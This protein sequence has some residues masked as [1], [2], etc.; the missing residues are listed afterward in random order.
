MTVTEWSDQNRRL[1]SEASAEPGQWITTR[2]AYQKGMM[3]AL[4][5]EGI[6]RIVLMTSSQ[7]GKTE[8]LNNIIGFYISQDP[9]PILVMQPTLEIA[10]TW[11]KDRLSP[12]LR[13]T[14]CLQNLVAD[15]RARDSG[16]TILHKKFLGGHVTAVGANSPAGLA[17]RPIRILL[18]DEVDRY[19]IS[20]GTEG[21]PLSLAIKR[22]ATFWNRRVVLA[23][24]PTIKGISR[25]ESEYLRSDQR[26]Y[27][28]K[29][30]HCEH[31]QV[32]VW[33]NVKWPEGKPDQAQYACEE[34]GVLWTEADRRSAVRWGEWKATKP[35]KNIAGFH[36]N[37]LYSPWSSI[38]D[39]A[40]AFL[41]AKKSAETLKA[42]VNTSLGESWEEDAERIDSATIASRLER[43][44]SNAVPNKILAITCGVDC[45]NDRLEIERVGWCVDEECYSL[46]H[47]VIF[48]DPSTPDL[49]KALDEYLLTPTI[50]RDG[51][52]L[53]V[54]A[55][56]IDSGGHY[57]QA[58]Y[59]FC[60]ERFRRRVYA[61]KGKG[62]QGIPIWPKR[63]SKNNSG[64][65]NLFF[66]GVD[67]AKDIIYARL[68]IA[69]VGPGYCHFPIGRD[70]AYFDQ[71][72]SEIIQTK[73]SKGFATRVYCLPSGKRNEALDI[74]VYA[75]A[76]LQSLN[77]RWGNLLARQGSQQEDEEVID[78]SIHQIEQQNLNVRVEEKEVQTP[79]QL[80]QPTLPVSRPK[81]TR[82]FIRSGFMNG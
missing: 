7:V 28:C 16:N 55:T 8:V 1:S 77:I 63:A 65:V 67:A 40:I 32:L 66:I 42:W 15:P 58:V 60:R 64:R 51:I 43:W 24:T 33:G 3:D 14:P 46:E 11:A 23:S 59:K 76:A 21:D 53:P 72:T 82:R 62:G 12:M 50:R 30:P 78:Q 2:A 38:A 81:F 31:K 29:C 70:R 41:N 54:E 52:V 39:I 75:Y 34:C 25:I 71:L 17:S 27:F 5:E 18:A 37:E 20:A 13:D 47:R 68:K 36:L 45:Q 35:T 56:C 74:R 61:I 79:P 73:Y 26:K 44:D 69:D 49:W 4:S 57:T 6:D 48:G 9:A 80:A 19:P 10:E 22:T